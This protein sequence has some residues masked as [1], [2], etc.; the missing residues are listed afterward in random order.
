MRNELQERWL[1]SRDKGGHLVRKALSEP[2]QEIERDDNERAVGLFNTS[3]ISPVGIPLDEGL[4]DDGH[5]ALVDR[6]GEWA[7]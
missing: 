5:T 7:E 3:R 1:R 6:R 2:R 4:V